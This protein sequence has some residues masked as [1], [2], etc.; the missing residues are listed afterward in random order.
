MDTPFSAVARFNEAATLLPVRLTLR[1]GAVIDVIAVGGDDDGLLIAESETAEPRTIV[2]TDIAAVTV[3]E[4]SHPRVMLLLIAV[5]IGGLA[6]LK[7]I[8]Q[9]PFVAQFRDSSWVQ[10]G[11]G[12]ALFA[13][14]AKVYDVPF[15]TRMLQPWR[16]LY[17]APRPTAD[18]VEPTPST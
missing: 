6:T 1:S 14:F 15:V 10:Y 18:P 2:T 5:I 13:L 17:R 12:C 8:V 16:D 9:L 11:L 3:R 4:V 7:V